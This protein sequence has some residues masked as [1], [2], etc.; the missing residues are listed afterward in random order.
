MGTL[1]S[2]SMPFNQLITSA[3]VRQPLLHTGKEAPCHNQLQPLRVAKS[4]RPGN[5]VLI[6][7][8]LDLVQ[9]VNYP[10]FVTCFEHTITRS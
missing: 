5:L 6:A 4:H 7:R 2:G 8:L 1:P 3:L 9:D 10:P